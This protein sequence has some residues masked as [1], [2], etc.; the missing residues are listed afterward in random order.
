MRTR[1]IGLIL[2]ALPMPSS[3]RHKYRKRNSALLQTF[4]IAPGEASHC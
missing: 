3:P 2:C 4:S 1:L